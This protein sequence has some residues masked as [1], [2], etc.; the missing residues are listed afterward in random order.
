MFYYQLNKRDS[1]N[2]YGAIIRIGNSSFST[3]HSNEGVLASSGSLTNI[4]VEREFKS[5]LPQPYSNCQIDPQSPNFQPNLDN[6]NKIDLTDYTYT[7]QFCFTQCMQKYI[8]DKYNCS[9]TYLPSLYNASECAL[10][11][12]SN[13]FNDLFRKISID[14]DCL[15]LCPLQCN[16]EV[17]RTSVSSHQVLAFKFYEKIKN[18]TLLAS[19]FGTKRMNRDSIGTSVVS[20]NIF[21]QS[22]SFILTTESPRMD[23][24]SLLASIG[25]NLGLFL[26]VSVFSL[27][28]IIEVIIEMFYILKENRKK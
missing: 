5:I 9:I 15:P 20:V 27:C 25:G 26:G 18:K 13:L 12:N 28:E 3:Y 2:G 14:K 21:Y 7:Q 6:F 16:E 19:D 22:L 4:A 24:V 11:E 17:Y 8:I 1:T 10:D 23:I